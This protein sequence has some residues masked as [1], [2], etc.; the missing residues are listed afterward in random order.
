[1]TRLTTEPIT[2]RGVADAVGVLIEYRSEA[3]EWRFL[4]SR[5]FWMTPGQNQHRA[6]QWIRQ[7]VDEYE[8]RR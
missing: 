6:T 4:A 8:T 2:N 7:I 5:D 1:M 3:G